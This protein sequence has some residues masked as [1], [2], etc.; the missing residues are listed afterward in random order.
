[1]KVRNLKSI[2]TPYDG[3]LSADYE[4]EKRRL[5]FE[6][7]KIQQ[8]LIDKQQRLV[9]IFEGRDAAGKASTIKRFTEK[10]IPKFYKT[11]DLGIPTATESRNWLRRYQRDFPDPGHLRFFDRSW[12]SR[13]LVEPTMGYCSKGQYKRFMKSVLP[14]EHAHIENG[15]I[16]IKLYLSVDKDTQLYRLE[17]R[18]SDPLSFWKLSDSDINLRKKWDVFTKFKEQMFEYTSSKRSPWVAITSNSKKEAHLT[19]M[20]YVVQRFV[21]N[22]FKPL[23]G[24]EIE[25]NH[26]VEINGV[27]FRGLTLQQLAILMELKDHKNLFD[28]L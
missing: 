19:S 6:L 4:I 21:G 7:L 18:L 12:Y 15:L 23:T 17:K 5:Q 8:E 28:D 22:K 25:N 26:V 16:L 2:A 1:M 11:I 24:E 10:L 20:L 27:K 9:I 14:W 3:I 13:A